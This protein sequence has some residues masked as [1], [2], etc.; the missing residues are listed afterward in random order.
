ML[1]S[2]DQE[3]STDLVHNS[4]WPL[5]S[6]PHALEFNYPFHQLLWKRAFGVGVLEQ[7]KGIGDAST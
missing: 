6:W 5:G 3:F 4:V 1:I 2:V 7:L